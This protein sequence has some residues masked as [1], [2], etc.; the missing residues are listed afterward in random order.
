MIE[1]TTKAPLKWIYDWAMR[2]IAIS[3]FAFGLFWTTGIIL[4]EFFRDLSI[5]PAFFLIAWFLVI[6]LVFRILSLRWPDLLKIPV[7][8]GFFKFILWFIGFYVISYVVLVPVCAFFGHLI[9]QLTWPDPQHSEAGIFKTLVAIWLPLWWAPALSAVCVWARY[10]L[11][12]PPA[13]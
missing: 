10:R 12:L 4:D 1:L 3:G 11:R 6:I 2:I 13:R 8:V 9:V 5:N 7:T